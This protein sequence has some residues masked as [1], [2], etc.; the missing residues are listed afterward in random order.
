MHLYHFIIHINL[1]FQYNHTYVYHFIPKSSRSQPM[2]WAN[3]FGVR[4]LSQV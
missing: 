3:V 1:T 4:R 2:E